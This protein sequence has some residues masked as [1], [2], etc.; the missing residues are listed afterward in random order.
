MLPQGFAILAGKPKLGKSFMVLQMA[1]A[2]GRGDKFLGHSCNQGP[3]LLFAL[4][5]GERRVKERLAHLEIG[6]DSPL[7][8][9]LELPRFGEGGY[10]QLR[11]ILDEG[12]DGTAFQLIIIDSLSR[13]KSTKKEEIS[14][15]DM[16]AIVRPLQSLGHEMA[17]AFVLVHHHR[18]GATVKQ[19]DV[20]WDPR[21]SGAIVGVADVAIGIY[22]D[23]EIYKFLTRSRDAPELSYILSF[24]E[25]KWSLEGSEMDIGRTQVERGIIAFIKAAGPVT[26]NQIAL[27]R[28]VSLQVARRQ[29]SDMA[30]RGKLVKDT[31]IIPYVYAL[32]E[33]ADDHDQ[34]GFGV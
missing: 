9:E 11:D 19:A 14:P 13:A 5:D 23:K 26:P 7:Q 32:S 21:G 30:D 2:V 25:A 27:F 12:Y 6:E 28:G 17:C 4:E 34:L 1:Q 33:Q 18:K 20:I 16:E 22:R 10:R 3:T 8:I 31:K 15:E 24:N 29:L